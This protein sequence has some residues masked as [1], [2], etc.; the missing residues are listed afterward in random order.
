MEENRRLYYDQFYNPNYCR[1]RYHSEYE[2]P[3]PSKYR[4]IERQQNKQ[5]KRNVKNVVVDRTAK[6]C[7]V[8]KRRSKSLS[9]NYTEVKDKE[10]DKVKKRSVSSG[11]VK[12]NAKS[13]SVPQP[14]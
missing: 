5:I 14:S 4:E 7:R 12:S 9:R 6:K 11:K 8:E 1:E 3:L 10:K 13:S 2:E